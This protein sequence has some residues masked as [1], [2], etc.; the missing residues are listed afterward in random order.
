MPLEHISWRDT[1]PQ[2]GHSASTQKTEVWKARTQKQVK[3]QLTECFLRLITVKKLTRRQVWDV[4]WRQHHENLTDRV[5]VRFLKVWT[6]GW[7]PR[8][9]AAA[10]KWQ[11]LLRSGILWEWHVWGFWP[12]KY[13]II[14]PKMSEMIKF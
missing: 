3:L 1:R 5:H 8:F 7:C 2:G 10:A 9:L 4:F 6:Q 14:S 13:D 12:I 11:H